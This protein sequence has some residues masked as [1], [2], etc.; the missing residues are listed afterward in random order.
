MFAAIDPN[1]ELGPTGFFVM[2]GI[3]LLVACGTLASGLHPRWRATAKW[4]GGVARSV[5]GSL[6]FSFG[7]LIM[8]VAMVARGVLKQHGPLGGLVLWIFCS[9]AAFLILGPVYD[10]LQN[11]RK[12]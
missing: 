3:C 4:R 1:A 10:L 12:S 5:V 2:A 9:G 7:L 11:V 6:S 8:S